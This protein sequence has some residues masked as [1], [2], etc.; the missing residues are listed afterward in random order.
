MSVNEI[1]L[2]AVLEWPEMADVKNELADPNFASRRHGSRATYALGCRG[3]L[4]RK[5]ER[6]RARIRNKTR[7]QAQ[8][9]EYVESVNRKYDRDELLDALFIWHVQELAL[10]R[11]EGR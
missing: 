6:D 4:C 2:L 9:R 8:H 11:V 10:R 7:A 3:P 5:K 1:S